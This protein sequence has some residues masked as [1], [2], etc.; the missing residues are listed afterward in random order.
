MRQSCGGCACSLTSG[1]R[2]WRRPYSIVLLSGSGGGE[3]AIA[4]L[5]GSS[6]EGEKNNRRMVK[7]AGHQPFLCWQVGNG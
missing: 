5:F 1:A 6:G 4:V 3:A 2:P 7:R